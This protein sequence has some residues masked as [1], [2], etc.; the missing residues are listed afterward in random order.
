MAPDVLADMH[1]GSTAGA[2]AVLEVQDLAV[3]LDTRRGVV[4]AVNGVSY[5]VRAG[6]IVGVIGETGSGKTVS[7]LA[8]LGLL[9]ARR[10][11]ISA[12]HLRINGEEVR[13]LPTRRLRN[14][15]GNTVGV[16]FQDP[17]TAL[18]PTLT[19]RKQLYDA[20]RAHHRE[21]R[22]LTSEA[23]LDA[24]RRAGLPRPL[25]IMHR[26]PHELSGGMRQR[27]MIALAIVNEPALIVAD[28]PTTGLDVT[29]QAQIMDLMRMMRSKYHTAIIII[30]HDMGVIAELCDRVIVMYGGY[31]V[32]AGNVT[33]IFDAP[34]NPYTAA[35][36]ASRPEAM[37]PGATLL[38]IP[39]RPPST[40]EE[41]E[42][43]AFASRCWLSRGR[44]RCVEVRPGLRSI[45]VEAGHVTACH[46]AE[47]LAEE[48]QQQCV[49]GSE[50]ID[51][52]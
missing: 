19:I 11:H 51:G 17:M 36:L 45:G 33:E 23:S 25:D 48:G 43:C 42:G 24:L 4:R 47:E 14:L 32:E 13:G 7:A 38:G 3:Q 50:V 26:Y 30:T 34:L 49:G 37:E 27:V 39:G 41:I 35:L 1:G 40:R 21:P 18:N 52:G 28:E 5:D 8:P 6:E 16:I 46:F 22:S 29:V 20:R 44:A 15:R 9:D 2:E 12:T 10:S 31:V